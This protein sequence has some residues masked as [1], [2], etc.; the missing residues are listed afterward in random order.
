MVG[1]LGEVKCQSKVN[2]LSSGVVA[3]IA[4]VQVSDWDRPQAKSKFAAGPRRSDR[5]DCPQVDE[6]SACHQDGE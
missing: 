1:D 5:I 3:S 2:C 4:R 6:S